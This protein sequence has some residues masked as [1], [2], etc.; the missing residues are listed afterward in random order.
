MTLKKQIIINLGE[1]DFEHG[2][3]QVTIRRKIPSAFC[4]F[5]RQPTPSEF[6]NLIGQERW[7]IFFFSG[8]SQ[9]DRENN[10][11]LL[12]LNPEEKLNIQEIKKTIQIAIDRYQGMKLA[13]FN[14]C[15]GLGLVRQLSDLDI[16][17]IIV[18][19]EPVPD[20]IAQEFLTSFLHYFTKRMS[21][22]SK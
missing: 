14:S 15:D 11:T 8:H 21:E 3:S 7:N 9:T 12:Y 22:K 4:V 1:G 19:R 6:F 17:Q 20:E 18:W 10:T 16:A 5:L 2:F 13:I